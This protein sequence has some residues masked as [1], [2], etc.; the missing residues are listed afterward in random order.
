MRV[1]VNESLNNTNALARTTYN[2]A[3]NINGISYK[4]QLCNRSPMGRLLQGSNYRSPT[5]LTVAK[6]LK[7]KFV[8][9][10]HIFKKGTSRKLRVFA[11]ARSQ[12]ISQGGKCTPSVYTFA[13]DTSGSVCDTAILF[14]KKIAMINSPTSLEVNRFWLGR[15][16][17]GCKK[18]VSL[19]KLLCCVKLQGPFIGDFACL[20][21]KITSIYLILLSTLGLIMMCRV[22]HLS[23]FQPPVDNVIS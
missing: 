10:N 17:S 7:G 11:Q 3:F 4:S 12:E 15:E 20:S 9:R 21:K 13:M 1:Y 5:T 22:F 23:T 18:H 14:L 19:S 2:N 8:S 16:L 6:T